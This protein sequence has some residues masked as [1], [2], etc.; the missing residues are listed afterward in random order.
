LASIR[1]VWISHPHADHHLGL[2]RLLQER[3]MARDKPL[4][5]I[6]PSCIFHFLEQCHRQRLLADGPA[7]VAVDCQNLVVSGSFCR[8]DI[9]SKS[10]SDGAYALQSARRFIDTAF[11]W[12]DVRAVP[13][14]H[15]ADAFAVVLDG[16]PFGRLVYS[17][18]CRPTFLLARSAKPVDLLIHEATFED[19]REGEAMLKKHSTIGEALSVANEM[20]ASC[21]VLTHFSQ[22]YPRIPPLSRSLSEPPGNP[23]L[24]VFAFDYMRLTPSS[25][26][27]A[28]QLTDVLRLLY[29]SDEGSTAGGTVDE[30]G[31]D[32]G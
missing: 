17:G 22:R 10:T 7:Y 25:L 9:S 12:K 30:D 24:V 5:L 8:T 28:S 27:A 32:D 1:A 21:V 6:A 20:E 18:D 4:L 15:C 29:P 23:M 2:L 26:V 13:V 3:P 11:G 19:G 14:E 31:M 16:T